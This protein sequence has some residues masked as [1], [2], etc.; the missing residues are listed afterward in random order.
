MARYPTSRR[1]C[2]EIGSI[3]AL[4]LTLCAQNAGATAI[5]LVASADLQNLTPGQQFEIVVGLDDV[6]EIGAYTL[7]IEFEGPLR[8]VSSEQ[9]ATSEAGADRFVKSLFTLDPADGLSVSNTGRASVLAVQQT[10]CIDGRANFPVEDPRAGFFAILFEA[11]GP[12]AG[13]IRAGIL[14]EQADFISMP[15]GGEIPL[16]PPFSDAGFR[17]VPE[18]SVAPLVLAGLA[19]LSALRR[20]R[21]I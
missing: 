21:R 5:T 3:A 11:G 18:P 7:D 13:L 8:F 14:D 6:T 2:L 10:L 9:L 16:D 20:S 15:G 4:V 17:I 12:G 1:R 19:A